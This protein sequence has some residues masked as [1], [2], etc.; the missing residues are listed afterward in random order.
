MGE[1]SK[2]NPDAFLSFLNQEST[3]NVEKYIESEAIFDNLTSFERSNLTCCSK[4]IIQCAI[5]LQ[6]LN[7][8]GH[9]KV[10]SECASECARIAE[11]A[12][13]GPCLFRDLIYQVLI[14]A[15]SHHRVGEECC[16]NPKI[17][18]VCAC[19]GILEAS[20]NEIDGK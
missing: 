17:F 20:F 3:S 13:E 8:F 2:W 19:L 18:C 10:L 7:E 11:E 14:Q 12:P 4:L 6:Y 5:S 9:R 1:S 15:S 16:M